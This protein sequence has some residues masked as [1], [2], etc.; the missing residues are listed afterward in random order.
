[1]DPGVGT[2]GLTAAG[3]LATM[4][5]MVHGPLGIGLDGAVLVLAVVIAL[6]ARRRSGGWTQPWI[7]IEPV[8]WFLLFLPVPSVGL[9]PVGTERD[10]TCRKVSAATR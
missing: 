10:R 6:H 7:G 5:C 3:N 8:W 1:M 4:L 2:R 9:P